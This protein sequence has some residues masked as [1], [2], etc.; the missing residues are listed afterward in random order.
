VEG[1]GEALQLG[2]R[3]RFALVRRY[4]LLIGGSDAECDRSKTQEEEW[5]FS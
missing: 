4:G 1:A 3:I 2:H 5:L